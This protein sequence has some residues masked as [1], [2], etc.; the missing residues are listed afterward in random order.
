MDYGEIIK[1]YRDKNFLSQLELANIL[2]AS[3]VMISRWEKSKY[4]PILKMNKEPKKLGIIT[5]GDDKNEWV[6]F[7][8][9]EIVQ[10][11]RI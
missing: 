1:E 7:E 10:I 2:G 11:G 3:F 8:K 9:Y 6:F 4:S 5:W